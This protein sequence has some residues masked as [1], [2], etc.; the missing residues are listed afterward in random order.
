M[1]SCQFCGRVMTSAPS[2]QEHEEN[3]SARPHAIIARLESENAEL[4]SLLRPVLACED[5][6]TSR[7]WMRRA[8]KALDRE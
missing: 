3:C 8:R 2:H 5:V 7:S 4:R 6:H 1:T